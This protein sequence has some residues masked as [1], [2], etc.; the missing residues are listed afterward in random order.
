MKFI[1]WK[2]INN[3]IISTLENYTFIVEDDVYLIAV[4]EPIKIED[5]STDTD[6]KEN[7]NNKSTNKIII[8]ILISISSITIGG[9]IIFIIIKKI[10]FKK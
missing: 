10:I 6:N 5:N 9:L 1:H 4:Y 2:D 3:N 8:N 7:N